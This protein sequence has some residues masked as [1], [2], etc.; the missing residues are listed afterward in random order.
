MLLSKRAEIFL[1]DIWPA[2]FDKA[3]GCEVWDLDGNRYFD[4]SIMGIG[5]NLLGYG[6]KEVDQAVAKIVSKGNMST[7]NCPEEVY[8]AEKLID[9]HPWSDMARFAFGRGEGMLYLLELG[10]PHLARRGSNLWLSWLARLVFSPYLERG[11]PFQSFASWF[12]PKGVPT[13]LRGSVYGFRYN[14]FDELLNIVDNNEIGVIM[15]EVMR[16]QGQKMDFGK[17]RNLATERGIV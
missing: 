3:S 4:T 14:N 1:P 12:I 11:R 10:E 9:S 16:D 13:E 6:H 8:L 7:F 5:T 15:M 2:Y 17:V